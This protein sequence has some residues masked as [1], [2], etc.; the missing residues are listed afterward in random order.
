MIV[1]TG[2]TLRCKRT[3]KKKQQEED[4]AATVVDVPPVV[5]NPELPPKENVGVEKEVT[6]EEIEKDKVFVASQGRLRK[7]FFKSGLTGRISKD[8]FDIVDKKIKR[9]TD[10]RV[11]SL[12]VKDKRII[13]ED[14]NEEYDKVCELPVTP[15]RD[16][17]KSII[18]KEYDISRVSPDIIESLHCLIEKD[19]IKLCQYAQDIMKNSTRKTLF[20]NDIDVASKALLKMEA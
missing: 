9:L 4:T 10:Q 11:K 7:L 3:T 13:Y 2:E 6:T 1:T 16:Y 15:F 5:E 12:L 8:V 19:V 18:K 20:A 17:I 14:Q